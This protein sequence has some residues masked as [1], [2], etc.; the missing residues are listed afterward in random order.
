MNGWPSLGG[1]FVPAPTTYEQAMARFAAATDVTA[2]PIRFYVDVSKHPHSLQA[3][4]AV[5]AI[6]GVVRRL[7]SHCVL[8]ITS[9]MCAKVVIMHIV[10]VG[11][12]ALVVCAE[13]S[14]TGCAFAQ[15][16]LHLCHPR[17]L[18]NQGRRA[19]CVFLIGPP[20]CG[21]TGVVLDA[22]AAK[23]EG[24]EM[25]AVVEAALNVNV[26][27]VPIA[28]V[29]LLCHKSI[30]RWNIGFPAASVAEGM[31]SKDW[32]PARLGVPGHYAPDAVNQIVERKLHILEE[33]QAMVPFLRQYLHR[34]RV[35]FQQSGRPATASQILGDISH[36]FVLDPQQA[37][38][39][40]HGVERVNATGT[41][42][43]LDNRVCMPW[44][45]VAKE[46]G[47]PD[48]DVHFHFI[49]FQGQ[50]RM[51]GLLY[52]CLDSGCV[53]TVFLRCCFASHVVLFGGCMYTCGMPRVD[54]E[55]SY[56]HLAYV[57]LYDQFAYVHLTSCSTLCA[58]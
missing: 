25:N 44:D 39:R 27:S 32:I 13:V 21:K 42:V 18:P 35:A 33:A 8:T 5:S 3:G 50:W 12:R 2:A 41:V 7:Y 15:D 30:M 46:L 58:A 57:T 19:N 38:C 47:P 11:L 34:L 14:T 49:I 23:T 54:P 10:L 1:R 29:A 52:R 48:V 31:F 40:P 45:V 17:P 53:S 43:F 22:A 4:K 55:V 36:I 9:F 26:P 6:S 16:L 20:G 28:Q 24:T 56:D 51:N 37:S